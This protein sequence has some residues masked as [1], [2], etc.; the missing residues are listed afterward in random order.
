MDIKELARKIQEVRTLQN[1]YFATR[2]KSILGESKAKEKEIDAL[3]AK[4]LAEPTAATVEPDF[5]GWEARIDG[6]FHNL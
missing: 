2:S 4:I 6:A 1:Q 3:V 5:N